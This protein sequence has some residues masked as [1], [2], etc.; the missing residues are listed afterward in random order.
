MKKKFKKNFVHSLERYGPSLALAAAFVANY[1]AGRYV[2]R[3]G[4]RFP[5]LSGDFLL[6]LLPRVDLTF[7]FIWGFAAFIVFAM[8]CAW[9]YERDRLDYICWMYAHL[10][11]ARAFFLILTPMGL[12]E[13]AF[14]VQGSALFDFIGRYL[15]FKND[16]FF[17]AHTAMPFLGFLIYRTPWVRGVFFSLSLILAGTVLLS[18][19][20]YS[21]DVAGAYFITMGLVWAHRELVEPPYRYWRDRW[22]GLNPKWRAKA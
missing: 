22:L 9:K 6:W 8:A 16:L 14:E 20:H 4:S 1:F 7:I 21:I 17:S 12:P 19:L 10:I 11:G 13:G 15:T 18:R 3:V 5:S 2:D